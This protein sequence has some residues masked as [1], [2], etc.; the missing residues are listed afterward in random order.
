[1]DKLPALTW[2]IEF[3]EGNNIPY[4]ACGGIAAKVYGSKR[5]LN[6]IDIYVPDEYFVLVTEFG[7]SYITYGPKH[8]KDKQWDL[9][10]VKFDYHGQD[11]EVG[12]DKECKI[13]DSQQS[14]W[15]VQSI[16]FDDYQ[17]HKIFGV[18][19]KVMSKNNLIAYKK[20]LSRDVDIDDIA[21][22]NE[23]V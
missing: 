22:I 16:D 1:M 5:E 21:Q 3:L 2:I 9:T 8:Y 17:R 23:N 19:L 7:S 18:E 4:V 14:K 15:V 11:V 12:S 10:Y 13:Y 6:D 20:Q